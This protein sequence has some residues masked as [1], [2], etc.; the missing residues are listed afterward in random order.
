MVRDTLASVPGRV[1]HT[2]VSFSVDWLRSEH[3]EVIKGQVTKIDVG[4]LAGSQ[5]SP[6]L[7]QRYQ[8]GLAELTRI[9]RWPCHGLCIQ[10]D[11]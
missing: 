7:L 11:D 10:G 9:G 2:L 6:E 5:L 8:D 1:A 3:V 4:E